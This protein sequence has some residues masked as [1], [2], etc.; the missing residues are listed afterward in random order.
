M[1]AL[2]APVQKWMIF[3]VK[4]REAGIERHLA[5]L[6]YTRFLERFWVIEQFSAS[7]S[8]LSYW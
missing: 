1:G 4:E 8:V 7:L 6:H 3:I 2:Q 5:E